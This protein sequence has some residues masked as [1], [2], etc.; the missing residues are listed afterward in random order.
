MP[1]FNVVSKQGLVE[2]NVQR[3]AQ[4]LEK[5][6]IDHTV[7][8]AMLRELASNQIPRVKVGEGYDINKMTKPSTKPGTVREFIGTG[9]FA[10]DFYRRLQY[11]VDAGRD[12]EPILFPA[13]YSVT[14]DSTLPRNIDV[15]VL[16]DTGVVFEEVKEGSEVKFASVSQGSKTIP[17]K[18]YAVGLEYN[19]DLFLYNELWRLATIERNFGIAYNA[20][21]NHIH[22]TPI[23][24]HSYPAGNQTAASSDGT[25]MVEKYLRTIEQAIS[26]SASDKTNPRPGPYALLVSSSDQFTVERALNRVP[27]EGFDLQSSALSRVRTIVTYDGWSGMR[28]NKVTT[29]DGV[30]AGKAYLVSLTRRDLDYQSYFKH[31]M[32]RNMANP[33]LSRFIMEQ[34]VYDTRFGVFADPRKSVQEITWPTS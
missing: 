3:R 19:E 23:L 13:L 17:I 12:M 26:S 14:I 2:E 21:L 8:D 30:T 22:M 15:S 25:T 18:H 29:Y 24:S 9:A 16:G 7:K 11:E 28:G 4:A 34:V 31:E 6:N 1:N 10:S 27:Q 32:R 33:D 20:L 5:S